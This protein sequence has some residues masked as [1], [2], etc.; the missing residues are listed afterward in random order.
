MTRYA[1]AFKGLRV[2]KLKKKDKK[3]QDAIKTIQNGEL[4][5]GLRTYATGALKDA[6]IVYWRTIQRECQ[7]SRGV[8]ESVAG[9]NEDDWLYVSIICNAMGKKNRGG[10]YAPG[11]GF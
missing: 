3:I 5:H 2:V 4:C 11:K 10:G 8:N 1:T 6:D 7:G 9:V